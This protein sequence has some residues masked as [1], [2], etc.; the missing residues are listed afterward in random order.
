MS[1]RRNFPELS[2]TVTVS[3]CDD[4]DA[5]LALSAVSHADAAATKRLQQGGPL[6][7]SPSSLLKALAKW[8]A[9]AAAGLLVLFGIGYFWY[10]L[11]CYPTQ[12]PTSPF[13][14]SGPLAAADGS[15]CCNCAAGV[16]PSAAGP[17]ASVSGCPCPTGV[18]LPS[19]AVLLHLASTHLVDE[20]VR[21]LHNL[22]GSG[23]RFDLLVSVAEGRV[24]VTDPRLLPL[25]VAFPGARF[26]VVPNRGMDIGGFL[27]L[28]P[29]V[30]SG[31]YEFVL[32]LHSKSVR[33][34]REGMLGPLIGTPEQAKFN[35]D[36]F[37]RFPAVGMVAP[38]RFHFP[39]QH[40]II[41]FRTMERLSAEFGFPTFTRCAPAEFVGGTT[42]FLRRAVLDCTFGGR[43]M[44]R[45]TDQLTAGGVSGADGTVE[46]GWERFLGVMVQACGFEIQGTGML[47]RDQDGHARLDLQIEL[48]GDAFEG[49]YEYV[50]VRNDLVKHPFGRR[51]EGE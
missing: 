12:W 28:V 16:L 27:H 23:L 31:P 3:T 13:V 17:C 4:G 32:K 21:Y 38:A 51:G 15:A 40:R 24:D 10:W 36:L 37:R 30:L 45:I 8:I 18:Q 46:H 43:D 41:N 42:F 50:P 2:T 5:E 20:F 19:L 34:W 47:V 7:R 33:W 29:A 14:P 35:V 11:T 44:G 1:S 22:N 48:N 26:V 39:E 9:V 25:R 49:R 6:L